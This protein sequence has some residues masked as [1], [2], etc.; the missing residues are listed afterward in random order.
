MNACMLTIPFPHILVS[1]YC[2][3]F[4]ICL[5]LCSCVFYT[6]AVQLI[7]RHRHERE[8]CELF[9]LVYSVYIQ[10]LKTRFGLGVEENIN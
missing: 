7:R 4:R 10:Q 5:S 1:R 8:K 2:Y 6:C 9:W 3:V